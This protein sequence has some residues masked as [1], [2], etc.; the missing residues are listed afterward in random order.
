MLR[1]PDPFSIAKLV[2][3]SEWLVAES[4]AVQ[5]H[6]HAASIRLTHVLR[7]VERF[8]RAKGKRAPARG[9]PTGNA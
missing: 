5:E 4:L 6:A 9:W 1:K 7:Y 8:N 3:V 2:R